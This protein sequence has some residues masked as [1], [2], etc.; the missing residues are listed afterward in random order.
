MLIIRNE[1]VQSRVDVYGHSCA[2]DQCLS[3]MMVAKPSLGDA[4]RVWMLTE[5]A[6]NHQS[7]FP[8]NVYGL[9]SVSL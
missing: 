5:Y 1:W 7:L 8:F 6:E 3:P 9:K 4:Q 2:K